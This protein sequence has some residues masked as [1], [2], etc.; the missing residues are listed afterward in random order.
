MDRK[1]SRKRCCECRRWYVPHVA[2]VGHQKTCGKGCREAR[3]RRLSRRRRALDLHGYRLDE[4]ER[5]RACRA[6]RRASS[7]A[8]SRTGLSVQ[9][10]NLQRELLEIVD[11]H[12]RLSRTGLR[13]EVV[14]LL[15]VSQHEV[16]Q[17][18]TAEP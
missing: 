2:A 8:V 16:R 12:A 10:S 7:A 13:R 14:R 3:R 4:R 15:Q 17:A 5:Q 18:G 9:G 6:R 11:K 1:G